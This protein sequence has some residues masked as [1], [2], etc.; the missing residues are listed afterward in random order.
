MTVGEGGLCG[1]SSVVGAREAV[2]G[3]AMDGGEATIDSGVA[4]TGGLRL[5]G[6]AAL[7]DAVALMAS[8][9]T[10]SP[11]AGG[12]SWPSCESSAASF[13]CHR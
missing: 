5:A 6:A 1:F 3:S 11:T 8:A 12:L 9:G 10:S 4:L 2:V 7:S 13:C